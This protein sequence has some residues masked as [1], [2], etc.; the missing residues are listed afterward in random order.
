MNIKVHLAVATCSRRQSRDLK[1]A[2]VFRKPSLLYALTEG[3]QGSL[4][5]AMNGVAGQDVAAPRFNLAG[6]SH[7]RLT[8]HG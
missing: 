8:L 5:I 4:K 2:G 6:E 3:L 1:R 7:T